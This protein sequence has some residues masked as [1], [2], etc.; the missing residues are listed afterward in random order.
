MIKHIEG[1]KAGDRVTSNTPVGSV[2]QRSFEEKTHNFLVVIGH[3][4]RHGMTIAINSQG[5]GESF[6]CDQQ[7]YIVTRPGPLP[8]HHWAWNWL[9]ERINK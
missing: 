8:W 3:K 5:I 4:R 1:T 9:A 6:Y 7:D 2:I